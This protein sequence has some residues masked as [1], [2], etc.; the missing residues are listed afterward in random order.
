MNNL[1]FQYEKFAIQTY[2]QYKFLYDI[3]FKK[4]LRPLVFFDLYMKGRDKDYPQ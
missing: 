3:S 1:K 2:Y 4:S